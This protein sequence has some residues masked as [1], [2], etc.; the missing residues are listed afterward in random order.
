MAEAAGVYSPFGERPQ[1][2]LYGKLVLLTGIRL[3]VGT[4]LLAATAWPTLGHEP[5]PRTVE[6]LLFAI[7]AL[8]YFGSLVATFVLRTGRHLGW[9]AHGQIAADVIAGTGLVYLTG[10]AE[11]IFTVLYP[12]AIVSG[13]IGL[14]RRGAALGAAVSCVTFCIL[15][16][17]MQSGIVP[18]PAS[19]LERVP[20]APGRLTVVMAANLS[21]FLLVGALSSFL[22]EQVQGARSQ[23]LRS[24]KRLE[25]LEGIYS[26]VV[27]SIASGILTLGEDGRI[28]YLNPAAE[29]LTGLSDKVARG[30]P[31]GTLLPELAASIVRPRE[32]GRPEV[33]LKAYDGRDRILGYATAP[34]AGGVGGQVI[35]F[36]DLTELRQMEEAVRRADRLAVVGGLAAGL[37][38]EIRNPLASMCGS[39]DILG[40]SPGLDGQERRLMNVV[41]SEAERLEAL[42]REFLSFARPISPTFEP[43]DGA[44][45]VRETVELF[46]Q[47]VAERGVELIARADA[48]VWVRADPGQLRQVLW[49]LLGNAADAT[50]PGGRVEVTISRQAGEGVLEVTDTGHGI[51][52]EDLDRIFDPFFTTK[53]RGTGLGLAIVHRIVEAHSGH[54]SVSSQVDRGSTFRV[55]L[56]IAVPSPEHLRAAVG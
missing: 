42:V 13:A 24:E 18:P 11:S 37:A 15:V 32:R 23:L 16:W 19:E 38:H 22:A 34:L 31:L 25:A 30:Q 28:T 4:A 51:A 10:G 36:Q 56:P 53:E 41:R 45:A 21:A 35:L 55:A 46:R 50:A 9:V 5:F 49:N 2:G 27:R 3:A 14:G 39:I 1:G 43:L 40:A 26:A 47:Q 7:V 44:R 6:A 33:R 12:L 52:D 29:H 48:A 54:L 20:L 8:I 17:S